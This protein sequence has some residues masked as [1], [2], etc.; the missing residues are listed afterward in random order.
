MTNAE[1]AEHVNQC[2]MHYEQ[3]TQSEREN[4][5]T[6]FLASAMH[7]ADEQGMD[8]A[9][10][11]RLARD[12]Y[13]AEVEEEHQQ[14]A[15][16]INFT[17]VYTDLSGDVYPYNLE[18]SNHADAKTKFLADFPDGVNSIDYVIAHETSPGYKQLHEK[19]SE[20]VES[21]ELEDASVANLLANLTLIP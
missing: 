9:E 8:F 2:I 21:G 16:L 17:I 10:K 19:L 7:W 14:R 13:D 1:R 6:D 5:L 4:S 3:I 18:A 11:L 12:H 20:M 15:S